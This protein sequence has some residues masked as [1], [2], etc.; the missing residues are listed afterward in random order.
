MCIIEVY[1]TTQGKQELEFSNHEYLGL[2]QLRSNLDDKRNCPSPCIHLQEDTYDTEGEL[3]KTMEKRPLPRRPHNEEE[4][5]VYEN[6]GM[7][8]NNRMPMETGEAEGTD[9]VYMTADDGTQQGG[10]DGVYDV[11]RS[12][13]LCLPK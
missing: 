5:V 2:S 3:M 10:D 13:K 9:G 12:S 4:Q 11:I 7:Y 8:Y 1:E 6:Q